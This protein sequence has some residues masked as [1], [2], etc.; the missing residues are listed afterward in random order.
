MDKTPHK[1][2]KV[3]DKWRKKKMCKDFIVMAEDLE[4][5]YIHRRY[6][7]AAVDYQ[8]VLDLLEKLDQTS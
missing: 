6:D 7:I 5:E 2:A 4:N 3:W 1:A 8:D